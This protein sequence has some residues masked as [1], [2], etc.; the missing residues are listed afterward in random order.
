[1]KEFADDNSEFDDNGLKFSKW[2]EDTAGKG[3][4][5]HYEQF[6]LFTHCLQKTCTADT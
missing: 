2:V 3:E 4:I 1:M 6:L 5:D